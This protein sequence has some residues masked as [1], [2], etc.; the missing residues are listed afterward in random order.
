M[1]MK[2]I[3]IT[4]F[5]PFGGE[6][7]NPSWLAV[8]QVTCDRAEIIKKEL[9][10][11]FHGAR[12][13]IRALMDEHRPDYVISVGQA[14]GRKP[15]TVEFVAVNLMD[16]VDN[17]GVRMQDE[18]LVPCGENAIFATLPVRQLVDCVRESGVPCA[19]SLSA[20]AYVCNAVMYTALHHAKAQ[21][22][23]CRCGF[24]HVP[25]IPEQVVGKDAPAMPLSDIVRALEMMIDHL[26]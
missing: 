1:P 16:G 2:K 26:A 7:I 25:F 8:E 19:R 17:D 23:D 9:P 15:V 6:K 13:C 12:D 4:G 20:G 5:E 24:V 22:M 18:S 10:V 3:L 14:G 21:H 11:T